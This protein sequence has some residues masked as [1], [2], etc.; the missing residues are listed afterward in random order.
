MT[1]TVPLA[2]PSEALL[3]V[4]DLHVSFSGGP[5]VVRGVDLEIRAGE[6][7]AIVGESGSGKSVTARSLLGLAGAGASVRAGVM[8]FE[9]EDVS[10]RT[11]A[12]W[13]RIRGRRIG[14]ILQD[15]LGSLDPLRTI[16]R[17]IDDALR[18]GT[19]LGRAERSARVIDLLEA[20]GMPEPEQRV[21]LRSGELSG[22]L[23]QRALI[24]SAIALDPPLVIADE[25]TTALDV[26]VQARILELLGGLR[27]GGT[28]LLLISHDLAVVSAIADRVVVMRHGRI[29]ESGP[30][31]R[32]LEHP[33]EAY[34]RELIG[35]V[36]TD[37]PRWSRLSA[38]DADGDT[39]PDARSGTGD[40]TNSAAETIDIAERAPVG[41]MA[42]P[43]ASD[44]P[45]LEFTG[46]V[47]RFSRRGGAE[48]LLTVS[49][50]SFGVERG[51]SLGIVGESGSGKTTIA[52]MLLGLTSPDAGTIR[53]DGL[54]WS[55]MS[56]RQRRPHRQRIGAVYQDSLSS[57]DPRWRVRDI[58]ADA[59][60]LRA[61]GPAS[62]VD[63]LLRSVALD[64]AVAEVRP[65][66]LSG[67][68]RQRVAI[69]RA[70]AP[71]P[72]VLVL[73]EPVSAL[74]V[75]VQARVLDLL[76]ELQRERGL[77]IVFISHDLGVVR[78]MTDQVIVLQRGVIVEHGS[79]ER[80][81]TD[82]R[83]AYTA[84]LAADAPRI[85]NRSDG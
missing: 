44:T 30:T 16:G 62:T 15:A 73:D 66:T 34:T 82:P 74:D 55:G 2:D 12:G 71:R 85:R 45:I 72:D 35:A 70:L 11:E 83:H 63:E 49:D 3:Q 13:R 77:S 84:R 80:V 43:P 79:T 24:A 41:S 31:H 42:A 48:P 58:L 57:F 22:G 39:G 53:L 69:A 68:Q 54:D 51:T 59:A 1:N 32:I 36:P 10:G 37:R 14:L 67:G 38:V 26:T 7:V 56:E 33:R 27:D 75:T 46:V 25:P 9:G 40:D 76:D 6:C 81:F 20:V 50:A 19:G 60:A 5:D 21:G 28:G 78:H 8:R 61:H 29:V 18:L 65:R 64:P 17:E 4:R 52:R 23:R 47:K